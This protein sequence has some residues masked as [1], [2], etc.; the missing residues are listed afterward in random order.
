ML[1]DSCIQPWCKLPLFACGV[2]RFRSWCL[3]C[4][5]VPSNISMR[6]LSIIFATYTLSSGLRS[7]PLHARHLM[8]FQVWSPC[9]PVAR[10]GVPLVYAFSTVSLFQSRHQECWQCHHR[11]LLPPSQALSCTFPHDFFL[12]L[13]LLLVAALPSPSA[14]HPALPSPSAHPALFCNVPAMIVVLIECL[15]SSL[16]CHQKKPSLLLQW[17]LPPFGLLWRRQNPPTPQLQVPPHQRS[18]TRG[19]RAI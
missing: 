15:R 9:L 16:Q 13:T 6:T 11:C 1:F 17:P 8:S 10:S 5:A 2:D 7:R 3:R 18:P 4:R 14:H 19:L 12:F